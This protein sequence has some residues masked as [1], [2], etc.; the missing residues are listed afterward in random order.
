MMKKAPSYFYLLLCLIG[1]CGMNISYGMIA[2]D[3]AKTEIHVWRAYYKQD[4]EAL[5]APL[6]DFIQSHYAIPDA[7]ELISSYM[8][9]LMTFAQTPQESSQETYER[10]IFPLL[11]NAFQDF[12]KKS[13]LTFDPKKAAQA[14]LQWWIARRGTP[15]DYR[16][17]NV[18]RLMQNVY[19]LLY[20]GVL[21]DY[22]ETAFLRATAARLRDDYWESSSN[23]GLTDAQWST[24]EELLSKAYT[25]FP[26][27]RLR[28]V[29]VSLSS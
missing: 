26:M 8:S 28:T 14:E 19:V 3:L 13:T 1:F 7:E 5:K 29:K 11:E 23:K 20:G 12:Q 21:K 16:P 24:V 25:Q 22:T 18:G 9:A 17:E 2:E 6:R 15:D 4:T 10:V 27:E